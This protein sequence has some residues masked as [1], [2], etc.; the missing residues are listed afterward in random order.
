MELYELCVAE[1]T[2]FRVLRYVC[3]TDAE[4][5]VLA[6]AAVWEAATASD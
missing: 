5:A 2:S 3:N 6:A 1:A 4:R